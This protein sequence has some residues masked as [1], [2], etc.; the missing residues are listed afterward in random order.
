MLAHGSELRPGTKHHFIVNVR[1][2]SPLPMQAQAERMEYI[3]KHF[4]LND[5]QQLALERSLTRIVCGVHLVQGATG[6]GKSRVALVT[7][8]ILAVLEIPVLL[9]AKSDRG[10]DNLTR[11]VAEALKRHP[12]IQSWA[13]Q[14]V[15]FHSYARQVAELRSGSP[16]PTQSE[17]EA[18]ILRP[19]D[20]RN[21]ALQYAMHNRRQ[22]RRY[23]Q[24]IDIL[25]Q[26]RQRLLFDDEITTLTERY[27]HVV[28]D[29]LFHCRIVATSLC[30]AAHVNLRG[31][32]GFKPEF[33]VCDES[34]QGLEGY[35]AIALSITS[36]RAVILLGDPMQ[37]APTFL[38][39]GRGNEGIKF[40]KRPLMG[41]LCESGYPCTILTINHR[42]NDAILRL[43]Q[44]AVYESYT[45]LPVQ[46]HRDNNAPDRVGSVWDA[47]THSRHHFYATRLGG[48]RQIFISVDDVATR[49]GGCNSWSNGAQVD[50]ARDILAE[51]YAY[52]SSDGVRI[53]PKDVM[54]ISPYKE[55]RDLV[56]TMLREQGL[57][58]CSN[59][60]IDAAE[61]RES[62][63]VI[64]LMTLPSTN[65]L[66]VGSMANINRLNLALT[67]AQKVL[68]I[69]G[70]LLVWNRQTMW[71]LTR[72]KR[73]RLLCR[74][75]KDV[76][77]EGHTLT[78]VG[79]KTAQER[80]AP[81]NVQYVFHDSGIRQQQVVP[82]VAIL[83]ETHSV[84]APCQTACQP[85]HK[86][87]FPFSTLES[88]KK[89]K[90]SKG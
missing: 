16:C 51:L 59:L 90:I 39:E 20:I 85:E 33:L 9:A 76:S 81:Q 17:E 29:L 83:E 86:V 47:F 63:F 88:V 21:V 12:R 73:N 7:T 25:R 36:L 24:L 3:K 84:Q 37:I 89:P 46:A 1:S 67:R 72:D 66:N 2:M 41:R 62:P 38:S 50:V 80:D 61:G 15:R 54:I 19:Y 40:L 32:S 22:D 14:L 42:N 69:V 78:W 27:E 34:G 26:G 65:A 82:P 79:R 4:P 75:L 55:Q 5:D 48:A 74:L 45:A 77:N 64:F 6:T 10:V 60:T 53:L 58:F 11:A 57:G 30:N 56:Y 49:H 68:L 31:T 52:T 28:Q 8:L 71:K 87:S 18:D 70:N 13:G 43:S 35:H 44:E 23:D